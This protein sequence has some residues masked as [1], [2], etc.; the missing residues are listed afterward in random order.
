MIYRVG[1]PDFLAVGSARGRF[2]SGRGGFQNDS[3]RGRENFSSGRGYVRNDFGGRGDFSGRG[4]GPGGRSGEGY[5]QAR[6]RGVR[7]SGPSQNAVS[8]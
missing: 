1:L 4:R 2:P 5:H 6:G 3:F 7:R 8:E